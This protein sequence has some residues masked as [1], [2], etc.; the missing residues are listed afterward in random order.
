[1]QHNFGWAK[2]PMLHRIASDLNPDLP[3]SIIYGSRSWVYR[4]NTDVLQLFAE[5]RCEGSYVATYIIDDASHHVHAD[6][7]EEFNAQVRDILK[8]VDTSQDMAHTLQQQDS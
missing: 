8:I 1:M 6:K 3:V 2:K 7:P 4:L 5:A